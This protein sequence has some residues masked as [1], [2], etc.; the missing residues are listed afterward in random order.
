MALGL[1]SYGRGMPTPKPGDMHADI[2][3]GSLYWTP[4]S[5][6]KTGSGKT[7]TAPARNGILNGESISDDALERL[8]AKYG[9]P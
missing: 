3:E 8:L 4:A 6:M 5:T 2:P 9:L 1:D 7:I